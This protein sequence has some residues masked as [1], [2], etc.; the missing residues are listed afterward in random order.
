[1]F[2]FK[3]TDYPSR[4]FLKKA[5]VGSWACSAGIQT[6]TRMSGIVPNRIAAEYTSSGTYEN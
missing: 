1:M 3:L 2:R 4:G 5:P 6:E